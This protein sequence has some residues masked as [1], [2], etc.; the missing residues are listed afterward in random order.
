[1]RNYYEAI[2]TVAQDCYVAVEI[3][4]KHTEKILKIC[5]EIDELMQGIGEKNSIF[6]DAGIPNDVAKYPNDSSNIYLQ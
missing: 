6:N 4:S 5:K 1:M 3:V 2:F